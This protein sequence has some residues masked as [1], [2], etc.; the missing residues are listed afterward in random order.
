MIDALSGKKRASLLEIC[1][2]LINETGII[3]HSITFDGATVNL[4]MCTALGANFELTE[5][6]KPYIINNVTKEKIFCFLDPCHMLKLVRNTL[7]DKLILYHNSK[8]ISWQNIVSLQKLQEIK[9]L[10]A[11]TKIT[12]WHILYKNN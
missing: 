9:G 11:G 8:I 4:S 5:N 7:G 2:E 1:F 10:K 12:K 3:L 6:F